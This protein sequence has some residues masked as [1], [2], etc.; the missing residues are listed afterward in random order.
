MCE[1]VRSRRPHQYAVGACLSVLIILMVVFFILVGAGHG[2][3]AAV[4]VVLATG[5][6]AA[7]VAVRLLGPVPRNV[8]G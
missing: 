6:A 2:P 8:C 3:A 1:S 5:M 4:P 7:E